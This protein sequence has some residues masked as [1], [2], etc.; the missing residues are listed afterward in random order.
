M[1]FDDCYLRYMETLGKRIFCIDAQF[2]TSNFSATNDC[3]GI[4]FKSLSYLYV[5]VVRFVQ[6]LMLLCFSTDF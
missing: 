1:N 2:C 5:N 3:D 4:F 6:F